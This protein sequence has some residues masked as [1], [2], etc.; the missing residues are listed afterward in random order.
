MKDLNNNMI[1]L[2]RRLHAQ[3]KAAAERPAM[4]SSGKITDLGGYS[5]GL[6]VGCGCTHTTTCE[7]L[8]ARGLVDVSTP[9]GLR[10]VSINDKG[11]EALAESRI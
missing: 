4:D 9:S 10:T 5:A 1:E 8:I 11:S 7:A 6:T 3:K 2:L